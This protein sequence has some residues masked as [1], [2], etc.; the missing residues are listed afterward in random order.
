VADAGR[1][2]LLTTL[3]YYWLY[4]YLRVLLPPP[5][6]AAGSYLVVVVPVAMAVCAGVLLHWADPRPQWRTPQILLLAF[7]G[8]AALVSLT[9]GDDATLRSAG[10][11]ALAALWLGGNATGALSVRTLN[12]FFVL[13]IVFGGLWFLLGLSD[14]GLLPGQYTEGADRSIEWRVS[15]FPFVPES[16]FF[17]LVVLLANQLHRRGAMRMVTCGLAAYFVVFSGMRSALLALLLAEVYLWWFSRGRHSLGVRRTQ[18]ISLLTM[19]VML[20]VLS[21]LTAIAP[22][23]PEGTLGNYLFRTESFEDSEAALS[24]SVYRGWLW[25]QHLQMFASAPLAGLGS[26][27]FHVVVTESLIEGKED[28]GSEAFITGWLAR[29][30]LCFAPFLVYLWWLCGRAGGAPSA[31]PGAVFLVLGVAALAYGS[32]LVPYNFMFIVLFALL[33]SR[34]AAHQRRTSP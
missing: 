17:A 3:A 15:L 22:V 16:G 29:L 6:E 21:S 27:D 25:A 23:L 31:L 24:Q 34:P 18:L 11:L 1:A 14:Y 5:D 9:R 26:F 12:V 8:V 30:G 28:T 13:S 7:I 4:L 33:A 10:L 2:L 19:F 32:F 20:V